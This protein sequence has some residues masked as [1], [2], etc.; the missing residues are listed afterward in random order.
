MKAIVVLICLFLSTHYL[1]AF[2]HGQTGRVSLQR[3]KSTTKE[4]ETNVRLYLNTH[5]GMDSITLG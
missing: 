2:E 3:M 4:T 1:F 5:D